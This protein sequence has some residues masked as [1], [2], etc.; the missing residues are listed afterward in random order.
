MQAIVLL[1]RE[2]SGEERAEDVTTSAFR[3]L[4][5]P[6][7]AIV[8]EPVNQCFN[9]DTVEHVLDRAQER[10][11]L[12]HRPRLVAPGK[13]HASCRHAAHGLTRSSLRSALTTARGE[14]R[15]LSGPESWTASPGRS[16]LLSV[17]RA[18]W[19][20]SLNAG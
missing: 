19:W 8:S 3:L 5:E 1:T 16:S 17:R 20:T 7:D 14:H 12:L 4:R 10:V 11:R 15:N 18:R 6:D 13:F 2:T 9:I